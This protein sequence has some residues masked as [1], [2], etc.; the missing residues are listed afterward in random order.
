MDGAKRELTIE[1]CVFN[2]PSHSVMYSLRPSIHSSPEFLAQKT[3]L[4]STLHVHLNSLTP[5]S[6]FLQKNSQFTC[7]AFG[8]KIICTLQLNFNNVHSPK[9]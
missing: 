2:K 8:N 3:R 5:I 7:E 9:H 1:P 6:N 4:Y